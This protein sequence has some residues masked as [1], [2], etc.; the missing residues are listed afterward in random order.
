LMS[1]KYALK[2]LELHPKIILSLSRGKFEG[3]LLT[4]SI[5]RRRFLGL[6]PSE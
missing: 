2:L 6:K 1:K 4:P 3:G 5:Q